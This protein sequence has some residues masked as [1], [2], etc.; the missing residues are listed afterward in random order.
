MDKDKKVKLKV[1][2]TG[3]WKPDYQEYRHEGRNQ[4]PYRPAEVDEYGRP[5]DRFKR[6]KPEKPKRRPFETQ[7][8]MEER[9][10]EELQRDLRKRN[11]K[12]S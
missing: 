3:S 12:P 6:I 7:K 5:V 2:H 8:K 4:K 9:L 10:Q 11:I 1:E